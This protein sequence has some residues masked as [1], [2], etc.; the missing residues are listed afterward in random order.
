MTRD[1]KPQH[2]Y[3]VRFAAREPVGPKAPRATACT[4]ISG[5]TTSIPLKRT[6]A[7]CPPGARRGGPVSRR[8]GRRKAF[9]MTVSLHARGAFTWREWADALAAELAA[10]GDGARRARRR[11]SL[12][13]TLARRA[14]KARRAEKTH[15]ERRARAAPWTNGTPRRARRRTASRSSCRAAEAAISTARAA[16]GRSRAPTV[17]RELHRANQLVAQDFQSARGA[18][19]ARRAH[20]VKG[21]AAEHDRLGAER[22]RLQHVDSTAHAAVDEH[23]H[24]ALHRARDRR[25]AS[26]EATARRA[27]VRRDWRRPRRRRRARRAA[28]RRRAKDAFHQHLPP[29]SRV[30]FRP[31]QSEARV[32]EAPDRGRDLRNAF[33]LGSQAATFSS[34]AYRGRS[35]ESTQRTRGE[36]EHVPRRKAEAD[37]KGRCG[38]PRSRLP[39]TGTSTVTISAS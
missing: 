4:S 11:H 38:S 36:I 27:G 16:R 33:R 20:P 28:R 29:A 17:P 8:R 25:R 23:A 34:A 19:F 30:S 7:P 12:L 5:M 21:R 35:T 15:P 32:P 13:R 31:S 2:C 18:R 9:A 39:P 26:S 24:P 1:K 37:R 6:F 3:S 22:D 14:G 10:A